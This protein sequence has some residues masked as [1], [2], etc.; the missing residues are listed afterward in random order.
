MQTEQSGPYS[1]RVDKESLFARGDD[2]TRDYHPVKIKQH[3]HHGLTIGGF[4]GYLPARRLWVNEP[5]HP[6]Q[7]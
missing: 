6:L 5:A 3:L 1:P 4:A 7:D 2:A